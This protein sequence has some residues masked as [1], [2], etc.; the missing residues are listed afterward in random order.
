MKRI[1]RMVALLLA[2]AIV[3]ALT[4]CG[5]TAQNQAPQGQTTQ[6]QLSG[7]P[8]TDLV[9]ATNNAS[10]SLLPW[11]NLS[12]FDYYVTENIYDSL[13]FSDAMFGELEPRLAES[14]ER[15]EDGLTLVFHLRGGITFHDG[16]PITAEDAAFSIQQYVNSPYIAGAMDYVSSID[17]PDDT[18][19]VV[20]LN[21]DNAMALWDV[22]NCMVLLKAAYEADPEA[23][24]L[25]PI[26]SGAYVLISNE[27]GSGALL[28][29]YEGYY[30]GAPAITT[31][32][33][34]IVSDLT[35]LDMGLQDGSI[36]CA[37]VGESSVA[38][39]SQ[40]QGL[41]LEYAPSD[42][43]V[44][45]LMNCENEY[46]KDVRVRQA[47]ASAINAP[48]IADSI[49]CGVASVNSYAP[50]SSAC[51]EW[52][53]GSA[54]TGLYDPESAKTMLEEAGYTLP[55]DL[56]T[57][58]TYANGSNEKIVA[59]IEQNLAEAGIQVVIEVGDPST[60]MTD[61]VAGNY[62]KILAS[63]SYKAKDSCKNG[64]ASV[65]KNAPEAPVVVEE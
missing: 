38:T 12:Y 17:T 13:M 54:G 47:I 27:S 60:I 29:A 4:G 36:D 49:L 45:L 11:D 19:V 56:G 24:R 28:Q 53:V 51:T 34:D 41:S 62:E 43:F 50:I 31:V 26:G 10:V 20:T 14:Y 22:A 63:E 55:I 1:Q 44:E 30:R 58:K 18:T 16:T 65:K 61:L 23:F 64:I 33:V 3:A 42:V 2:A 57:V 9:V 5:G 8:R 7:D 40:A 52:N 59:V 21:A 48:V 32:T 39:L 25:A 35:T 37:I 46:L 6:E 15:S